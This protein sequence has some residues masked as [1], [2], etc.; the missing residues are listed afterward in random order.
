MDEGTTRKLY[1]SSVGVVTFGRRD[2]VVGAWGQAVGTVERLL[3]RRE[4]ELE[5]MALRRE[6]KLLLLLDGE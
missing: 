2:R 5:L 6:P 4:Y 1:R 3:V